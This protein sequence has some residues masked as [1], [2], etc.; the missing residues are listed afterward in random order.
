MLID[1][2]PPPPEP[3]L[4]LSKT[5]SSAFSD[6]LTV[7]EDFITVYNKGDADLTVE[8]SKI[9]FNKMLTISPQVEKTIPEGDSLIITFSYNFNN[10]TKSELVK[11][12]GSCILSS[13]DPKN[14]EVEISL[15]AEL[16]IVGINDIDY[17]KITIYPNPTTGELRITASTSSAADRALSEVEVYD[18]YGRK[19]AEK[20]P[21]NKLEGWQAKPDGVVINVS[22][23][24]TG[25]Y[26]IRIGGN[27][28]KFVKL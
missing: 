18:I 13:N 3:L 22:H 9:D 4:V 16:D 17:S 6:K 15:L 5:E 1:G 20:F 24:P 12:L 10:I 23:L 2:P 25:I 26:F 14:K 28:Y 7:V 19:V 27:A 21:S 11:Y 8:I